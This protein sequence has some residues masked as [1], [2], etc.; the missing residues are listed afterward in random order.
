MA[1]KERKEDGLQYTMYIFHIK[2]NKFGILVMVLGNET[3]LSHFTG[4]FLE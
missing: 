1:K 4:R 2:V 3:Y